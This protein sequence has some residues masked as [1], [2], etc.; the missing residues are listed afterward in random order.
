[1][2]TADVLKDPELWK[3]TCKLFRLH[4]AFLIE[5]VTGSFILLLTFLRQ[6]DVDRFYHNHYRVGEGTL[7]QQLSH[8]LISDDLQDKVKGA[9]L[10]VRL[11]VKHEDYMQVRNR[12]GQGLDR[13][14]SVDNLLALPS[15]SR[16]VDHPSLR[17]LDLAVVSGQD[18]SCKD[19]TD[20]DSL[21]LT[22]RQVQ[23]ALRTGKEKSQQE[24]RQMMQEQVSNL[25]REVTRLTLENEGFQ[26]ILPEQKQEI[27]QLQDINEKMAARIEELLMPPASQRM[28]SE[29]QRTYAGMERRQSEPE[30]R[31]IRHKAKDK[32]EFLRA[33]RD[34]DVETVRRSLEKGV[35]VNIKSITTDGDTGLH[36]AC[37]EGHVKVVELLIKNQADLNV[38]NKD[39]D[40][41][42]HVA[43]REG[44]VKVVE[45]LI[46]NQADLN[47]ANKTGDTG[48]HVACSGGH[49]KVAELLI[50]N[51]ADLLRTNKAQVCCV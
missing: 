14:T 50:R 51:R 15:P 41:G 40:T 22:V 1:M 44:H 17:G 49:D 13:T 31:G 33:A 3:K 34:G 26:Q 12:L 42:L 43:C 4:K 29:R 38:A 39:G 37:R 45:L 8:I 23:T 10:I 36:V 16:Q 7:S 9:Q 20:Y 21:K 11:Q 18:Q 2:F 47:V 48:L 32:D 46:K 5:A 28:E 30:Y 35:D 27:N 25:K 19:E 6:T 24:T